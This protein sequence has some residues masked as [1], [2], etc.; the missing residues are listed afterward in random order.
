MRYVLGIDQG[1]TKT[2]VALSDMK[3]NILC[4]EEAYGSCHSV[5]SME[6]AMNA[7]EIAFR[8]LE[9]EHGFDRYEIESVVCGMTGADFDFEY[10]LLRRNIAKTLQISEEKITVHNDSVIALRGGMSETYGAVIC[11]GTGLNCAFVSKTGEQLILGYYID[12]EHQGAS[13]IGKKAIMAVFNEESGVGERTLL[14]RSVLNYYRADTVDVLLERYIFDSNIK[15]NLKN[16]VPFVFDCAMKKDSCATA[17]IMDFAQNWSKY[18]VAGAK[19]LL[20]DYPFSLVLS[21]GVF[22]DGS[23]LLVELIKQEIGRQLPKVT[24]VEAQFEPVVGAIQ[25]ALDKIGTT[26][27]EQRDRNIYESAGK[28]NLIRKRRN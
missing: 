15:N 17:I 26:D 21:G 1:G 14:T 18:M 24:F 19:K 5:Y 2:I 20:M 25:I 27:R 9:T 4:Y 13:A 28:N 10:P 8:N 7:I 11:A 6:H 3:G 16:L 12:D 23:G 22:K